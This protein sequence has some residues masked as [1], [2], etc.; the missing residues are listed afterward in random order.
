[1]SNI[2]ILGSGAREHALAEKFTQSGDNVLVAPGNDGI[3]LD[4]QTFALDTA[5]VATTFQ[6]IY[7]II[8]R[9][10]I[11]FVFVGNEQFL[12]DGVVDFLAERRIPTIGPTKAAAQI[13]TS[14]AFAKDLMTRH[15][16]PTA[17]YQSFTD[18]D[19]ALRYL[20][21]IEYPIVIKADGLAAGKGVTV[22]IDKHKATIAI[23]E[24]MTH[25]KFGSASDTIIIEEF[26]QGEEA[27]IFAFCDGENFVSTIFSQDHKQ[28]L[29][30]DLGPNTGGMGAYAPVDRFAHLQAQVDEQILAPTL[31]AMKSVGCPFSGVLYAGLMISGDSVKVIE[32]NCRFGDPETQVIL[33]LLKNSLTDI[34]R[35][36]VNKKISDI[37]LQWKPQYAVNVVLASKGYPADFEKGHPVHIDNSLFADSN[38]HLYFS[39]IKIDQQTHLL[40]NSGG[41][42]LGLTALGDTLDS[43]IHYAYQ[44]LPLIMS[45]NLRYRTD[46]G[47]RKSTHA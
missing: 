31:F 9:N 46:I 2:L 6:S 22:A 34:C 7:D 8:I 1:M 29:D 14:K 15:G 45:P 25:K 37:R 11:D 23:T 36:I 41:R 39:G 27:S 42:V 44:H 32:F 43:A 18:S 38:L 28:A 21:E 47:R 17:R 40:T 19:S 5:S 16:I 26:L 24:M 3:N 30:G 13:E 35:A 12:A 10:Q 20:Y 33:P 4:F